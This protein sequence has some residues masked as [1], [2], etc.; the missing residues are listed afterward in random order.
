VF[1]TGK[2]IP[3]AS[4]KDDPRILEQAF[5]KVA[6]ALE[7]GELVAIFPEGRITDNGEL[8]P[9]RPGIQ[10]IVARTPVPVIPLALKGLW[11]SFFSRVHGGKAMRNPLRNKLFAP[12]ALEAAPSVRPEMA[13]PEALQATVAA[14]RGDWR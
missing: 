2:A 6:E 14:L 8:Y 13:T 11:G 4:R 5:D 10:R 12:I 1:R 3:V 7:S 9:F